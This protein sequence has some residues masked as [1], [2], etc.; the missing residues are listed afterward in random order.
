METRA[1]QALQETLNS[2]YPLSPD[3]WRLYK[4]ICHI[5]HVKK[6]ELL[7]GL[8]KIPSS[9]SFVVKGIFR[10]Y[11]VNKKGQEYNKMFFNECMFPGP[12][13]AL[14]TNTSS[15]FSIEALEDSTVVCIDFKSYRKLLET[16][17]D[18]KMLHILYL[19]KNWLLVKDVRETELVQ[20]D[21]KVRYL[22]FIRENQALAKRIPQYHIASHLGITPTQLSRIR[23]Q[24]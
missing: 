13:T 17:H 10:A 22:R 12:M 2:Y 15:Q 18:L 11:T 8:N 19:E 7:Y 14:L 6:G 24:S 16:Q 20:E 23:K 21:A 4:G 1:Y 5:Q 3:T 9:F